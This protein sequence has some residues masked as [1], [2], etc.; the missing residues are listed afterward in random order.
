MLRNSKLPQPTDAPSRNIRLA[1]GC[2]KDAQREINQSMISLER[3]TRRHRKRGKTS[4]NVPEA[5]KLGTVLTGRE[6]QA[7]GFFGCIYS[8]VWVIDYNWSE[9][10]WEVTECV[11]I[12]ISDKTTT[13][14]IE[15]SAETVI[16]F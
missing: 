8:L 10:N 1:T 4:E 9:N 12:Y 2:R 15:S 7:R 11:H 14:N 16:P 6:G 5:I 3:M 13:K